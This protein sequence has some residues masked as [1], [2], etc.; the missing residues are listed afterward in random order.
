MRIC[1]SVFPG[2]VQQLLVFKEEALSEWSSSLNQEDPELLHI[3]EEQEEL[4]TSQ[5]GEQLIGLAE[6]DITR[7]P[8]TAVPVKSEDDEEKPQYSQLHQ[9]QTGDNREAEPP[10]SSSAK[11]IKTETDGEDCE[12]SETARNLNPDSHLQP[13]TDEKASD[14][15]KTESSNDDWQEP[16]SDSGSETEDS[17]KTNLKVH[18][19]VQTAKH[20][21]GCGVCGKR[22]TQRGHLKTHMRVHT[23][24]KRRE[25]I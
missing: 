15:F 13:N 16:L 23:G 6:A 2:D 19:G 10:A 8:F 17:Q 25:T 24:E 1:V 22:F 11:Q 18:M 21:F 4:W 5:E 3:S 12:G 20:P 7:F 14:S 9:S